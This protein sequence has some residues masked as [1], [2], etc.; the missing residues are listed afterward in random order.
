MKIHGLIPDLQNE[1]LLGA[2][3]RIYIL[4]KFPNNFNAY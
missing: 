4:I 2:G 1:T 3:S